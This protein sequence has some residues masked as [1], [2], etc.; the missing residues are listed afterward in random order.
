MKVLPVWNPVSGS[1]ELL[2]AVKR[3]FSA[4]RQS[5]PDRREYTLMFVPHHG[6]RVFSLRIPIKILKATAVTVGALLIVTA[7]AFINYE[8][9]LSVAN[10]EKVELERLKQVNATQNK[11]IEQ[12]A[13]TTAVLQ[14][15]MNR[16]NKLDADLRKIV[17]SDELPPSRSGTPRPT[18][19]GGQGGPIVK[20]D[21][22]DLTNLVKDLQANAKAR[23]QSLTALRQQIVDRNARLAATPSIWPTYGDVTS[24]FG[25][26]GSPWGGWGSDYHPGIDIAND[27]GTPINATADGYVVY[28]GWYS[29]YGNMIQIDHGNGIVTIYGHN[30]QNLVKVGDFVQKGGMIAYMGS[31]GY[32]TGSH[33]HYEVRVNGTAV[34][35]A[36]FL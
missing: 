33:C 15:D 30:S 26:R 1:K 22:N 27:Y 35:P 21:V 11:Q 4:E 19:N 32:S 10:A 25:W 24:R 17:S 13:K 7:G 6:K 29:G 3:K 23:E 9:T 14:D 31:T 34:N 12:L 36:N 28:S 5:R 18:A 8:R 16:L 20:P 2:E